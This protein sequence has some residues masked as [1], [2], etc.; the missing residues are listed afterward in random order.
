MIQAAG[1]SEGL[2]SAL[3]TDGW[4]WISLVSNFSFSFEAERIQSAGF[5]IHPSQNLP[6][7]NSRH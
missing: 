5:R 2:H 3:P 7:P 6:P 4:F 1:I